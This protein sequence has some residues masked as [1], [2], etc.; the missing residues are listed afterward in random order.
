M[1]SGASLQHEHPGTEGDLFWVCSRWFDVIL[2]FCQFGEAGIYGEYNIIFI[3]I[4]FE[5]VR[6]LLFWSP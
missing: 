1:G 5:Y 2:G 6:I 3:Y 4:E